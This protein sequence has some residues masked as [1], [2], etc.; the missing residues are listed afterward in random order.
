MP[1][2]ELEEV[3]QA[4][5]FKK[6]YPEQYYS[7][8]ISQNTRP[9]GRTLGRARIATVGLG[10]I[11]TA[12]SSA[13]VRIGA[14][15][16]IAAVKLEVRVP[17]EDHPNI[18]NLQANIELT[19]LCS[20]ELRQGRPSDVPGYLTDQVSS[21][22]VTTRACNLEQ[23]CIERGRAAWVAY[24]DIYILNNDGALLDACLLAGGACMQ[25]LSLPNVSV[26][27]EGN[28]AGGFG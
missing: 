10:V 14:T 22:L 27:D 9:D 13:L 18:G 8:F 26:N 16:V 21:A 11:S 24:L 28:H 5:A 4:D 19:S 20:S 23:L 3:L 17:S 12:D 7:R 1:A 25:A 6:L 2:Y 15:S